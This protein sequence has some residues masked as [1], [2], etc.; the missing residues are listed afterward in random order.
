M[1]RPCA[2]R[3]EEEE[4]V[5]FDSREDI[6]SVSDSC[7]SSPAVHDSCLEGS[8]DGPSSDPWYQVWIR[9][10]DSIRERRDKFMRWMGL[11][12]VHNPRRDSAD[13]GQEL[14]MDSEVMPEIDR[15]MLDGGAVLRS[16]GSEDGSSSASSSY[17]EGASTSD[18]GASEE[19][20]GYR[21]KNL[22]DGV[23]FVVDELGKDGSFR[24]LREVGSNRIISFH[25]FERSFG[26]PSLIQQLMRRE[27]NATGNSN[28]TMRRRRIGWLQRLGAV[29]C[30]VD[31]QMEEDSCISGSEH[32]GCAR[33]QRVKVR[34]YRKRSKE[35]SALYKGKDIKA[36]EGAVLTMKFSPNGQYLASGGEDGVVRVWRVMECER[37]EES[38][39]PEDDPSCVY[40]SVNHNSELAPLYADKERK[41]KLR[42]MK[43]TS[44]SACVLIPP[45]VFRISEKPLHE[46]HGHDG[47]VLDLSWSKNNKTKLPAYGKLDAIAAS[48]CFATA[49]MFNPVDEDYFV[50]G[51]ID[52]KARIW[53]VPG[54]H[55]VDWID[56]REIVTAV[57]YWPDGKGIVV[58]TLTGDCRFYD[59]SD[60]HLQLE[61]RV[62]LLGKKKPPFKRITGF[63][64]CPSDHRKLLVA[65]ADSHIRILDGIDVVSKYKGPWNA[66]SQI[67][68]SFTAD[69]RHIIS[70]CD[71]SNVYVWNHANQEVPSSNHLKSTWSCERFSS[72]CVSVAIP[73]HGLGRRNP[74]SVTFEVLPSHEDVS[75][76]QAGT[77]DDGS[78]LDQDSFGNNTLHLSPSGSFTLR[79]EFIS[80][81]LP[82]GSATWPEEKLP[83]SSM[84][85]SALCKSQYKFLKSSCQNTSHAWGQVIVTAGWDGRIRS[86]Q[87]YGL[88]VQL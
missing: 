27:D 57:C 43:R 69:G 49:I 73:W 81:F 32:S 7:P 24:S 65:S 41:A 19:K 48:K 31:R 77:T 15:I 66:G 11:D 44:D 54:C 18:D 55:V 52:G 34:L 12:P 47:D 71:D 80:E 79:H 75:L 13:H 45:E 83:S 2:F 51:S 8:F 40:F 88:P 17:S 62:P 67:S 61:V 38:D 36:H 30:V 60:N 84:T 10:P 86:F 28:K 46:F 1:A 23:M 76:D 68:A 25:E 5:F 14:N 72:D 85:T 64:F 37:N 82:K 21:I 63:Q 87:N 50:S 35:L 42:S 33:I 56:T 3:D 29:A 53:E 20:S 22:D 70:A 4:E 26:P 16:S 74:V 39:F 58:G 6:S 9:N 59:A 78:H